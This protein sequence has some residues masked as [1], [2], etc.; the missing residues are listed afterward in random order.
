MK[1]QIV[2]TT[3]DDDSEIVTQVVVDFKSVEKD[4]KTFLE[5]NVRVQN[6]PKKTDISFK[7]KADE[8]T[9]AKGFFEQLSRFTDPG[10]LVDVCKKVL[11]GL[12][13]SNPGMVVSRVLR[14]EKKE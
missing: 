9:N 5:P 11:G 12:F 3:F 1:H 7:L 2:A 13:F 8:Y 4:G 6:I 14:G 10:E